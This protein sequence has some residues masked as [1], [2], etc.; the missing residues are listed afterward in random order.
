MKTL[1]QILAAALLAAA[2]PLAI[3]AELEGTD[4]Q[5][6]QVRGES[7]LGEIEGG[8]RAML[9]FQDGRL[10]GSAGC[11]RLLGGYDRDGQS[12]SIKPNMASTMM[13]CPPPLMAQEQAVTGALGKVAS[14]TLDGETLRL[15]DADGE[16]VLV[17]T[18]LQGKPLAGTEWRLTAV[19]N[20]KGAVTSLVEGTEILLR[21]GDGGE[22]AG[23][24]CNMYRGGYS[25]EGERFVLEG[26]I[27][28]TK[29]A[30]V[31]PEGTSE[32]E[33]AYFAALE[34]VAS[35]TISGDT[36]T[37]K[38]ADGS[39]LARFAAKADSE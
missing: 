28:A 6:S 7:G 16:P 9:R 10:A 32:Q 18:Q 17:L 12:L 29:M 5:L 23:K 4:W 21:L 24:A 22:L 1:H 20:G 19:N 33:A 27:A 39:T 15:L 26:P 34:R 2:V 25:V 13:A 8:A 38:D 30:C 37:L 11:N 3:A 36:L 14:F 31:G 35:Y